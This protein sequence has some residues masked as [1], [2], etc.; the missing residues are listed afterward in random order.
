MPLLPLPEPKRKFTAFF[1]TK[2]QPVGTQPQVAH[3]SPLSSYFHLTMFSN[4]DETYKN[5]AK[6]AV[7]I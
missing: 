5:K 3:H 7:F 6:K 2:V 4:Q 1:P